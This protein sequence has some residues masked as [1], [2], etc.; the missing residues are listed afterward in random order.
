M[1][2]KEFITKKM[3]MS[4]IYQP[5]MIK[6]LLLKDGIASKSEIAE[7]ILR[8]DPSQ[9]EY[10]ENIVNNM[11]GRV[12]RNHGIVSKKQNDYFL[13]GF[14]SISREEL[15]ELVQLCDEK[16]LGYIKK[17]GE[18]V[19]DHRSKS[20]KT[21]SGSIKYKVLKRAGFR[22]ELCGISAKEKALE[23]D[24][25]VPKNMGGEDS[26]NNYQALCYTCNS[27]KRDHDDEDFRIL[28]TF[29]D[30]RELNCLF[31]DIDRKRIIL[32]NNLAYAMLDK[33]PVSE[34]H[35]LII[36][37]RHIPDYF[38][39]KQAEINAIQHLLIECKELLQKDLE[40]SSY[41]VGVN[42]GSDAGQTI[43]HSHIHLIPRREGDVD[44]PVGGVRNVIPGKG[45]YQYNSE[46][47][48][49]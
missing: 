43:M 7:E 29:Y 18:K 30:H 37:K 32:E 6:A 10:Y 23:V 44:N 22:C 42:S 38:D 1:Q 12:L 13:N 24:H 33:Y 31:C 15:T 45:D 17:R 4:H 20:R 2:L 3:R 5:V 21:I 9:V 8:Y 36:P 26:I 46:N 25:I 48:Q 49:K 47:M 19:W 35:M 28:K 39:L 16:I 41:N 34:G 40:I 11:V 14:E 27:M